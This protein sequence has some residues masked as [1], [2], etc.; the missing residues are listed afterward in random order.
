[1]A[2]FVQNNVWEIYPC[3]CKEL[4]FVGEWLYSILLFKDAIMYFSHFTG[5][6]HLIF[7]LV[8]SHCVLD[9][10]THSWICLLVSIYMPSFSIYIQEWNFLVLGKVCISSAFQEICFTFTL[11]PAAFEHS[12]CPNTKYHQS[13]SFSHSGGHIVVFHCY[14]ILHFPDSQWSWAY[15]HMC[16]ADL[17]ILFLK[18]S[19]QDSCPVFHSIFLLICKSFF[20][21]LI[22]LF[23]LFI[24]VCV[25]SLLL[26]A[27]FL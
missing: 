24:F 14:F 12:G 2:Y 9:Y 23:Y 27:G 22:Y 11:P 6:E 17:N 1:M 20:F 16:I 3:F 8:W 21:F 10:Y 13:F 25:G 15:F 7:F 4:W 26:R 19:F 18:E 5:D